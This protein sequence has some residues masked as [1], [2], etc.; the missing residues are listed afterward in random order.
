MMTG[1]TEN[2][3]EL[4]ISERLIL[5]VI[6]IIHS[7]NHEDETEIDAD[8]LPLWTVTV[9][10]FVDLPEDLHIIKKALAKRFGD[11]SKTSVKEEIAI[12]L[13]RLIPRSER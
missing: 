13:Q 8:N 12:N 10:D 6:F 7:R 3:N 2:S 4:Y 5:E 9:N 1:N 11:L